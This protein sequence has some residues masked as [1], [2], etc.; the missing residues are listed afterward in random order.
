[1]HVKGKIAVYGRSLGGIPTCHLARY[2]NVDL[3]I[4]DRT[5]SNLDI[6][7]R[8]KFYGDG[9]AKLFKLFSCGWET[10][11]D[12]N[13]VK[14]NCKKVMLFDKEDDVVDYYSSLYAGVAYQLT[15]NS[16]S[17]RSDYQRK[18]TSLL[19]EEQVLAFFTSLKWLY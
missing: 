16:S 8:R 1:M 13:Y 11:N 5:M 9:A 12:I 2:G 10:N 14:A 4:A 3:V 7:A 18:Y 17:L 15:N 19:S 6:I